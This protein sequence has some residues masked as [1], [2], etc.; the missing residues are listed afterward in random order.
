MRCSSSNNAMPNS[1]ITEVAGGPS[2]S[3][4]RIKVLPM[5]NLSRAPDADGEDEDTGSDNDGASD[6]GGREA[7]ILPLV[8]SFKGN[9]IPSKVC[10]LLCRPIINTRKQPKPY[11]LPFFSFSHHRRYI[12][13]IPA[14]KHVVQD[15]TASKYA[16]H[17]SQ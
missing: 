9:N 4:R 12:T 2:P 5:P 10:Y 13:T 6:S 15:S 11:F 7:L 17:K 14:H 3:I 16:I 8:V 1:S